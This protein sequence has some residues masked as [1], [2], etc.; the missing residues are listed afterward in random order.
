MPSGK[1]HT[2]FELILGPGFIIGF[3]LLFRPSLPELA[4]FGGAYLL[5]SL[6]LSPDLDLHKNR[7]RRRWGPLGFIWAPYSKIFKHRGVSH[8]LLLGPLTRLIYLGIV[9]GVVLVGL[10]YVGFALPQE[11]QITIEPRVL[12]VLGAGLYLPNLLHVLLDRAVS[13]FFT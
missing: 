10:S 8:N 2:A 1:T 6:F 7:A 3:Y 11:S 12:A 9:F 5:S 4:L 13:A